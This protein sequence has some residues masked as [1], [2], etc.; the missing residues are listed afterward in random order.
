MNRSI[1][2]VPVQKIEGDSSA[3]VQ[4]LLAIEEPLEI[5]LGDK[6]VSITMRTPGHDYELA[7]GFLFT[8]G[9]L[10]GS[11]QIH[12]IR[13]TQTSGNPR[14]AGNSVTVDLNPGVQVD[15]ERLER[16]FYT[17]SSCG[18][19]GKASI[20]AL[21]VQGCPVLPK[22]SLIVTSEVVHRLPEALRHQQA[23]FERTGGLHAAALFDAKGNLVLLHE[24]I[25]RHNAVDKVIGAEMLRD[26]TPLSDKLLLVSGRASF[27][28][29]QK[30]LMA[31]IPILAAVG[32]P[33][34]LA[35]ETAQR[36]QMTLLGF[37][38]DG[39]F[40]IYSGASR[41]Q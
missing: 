27:E 41:I 18:V 30:A 36:F 5:R 28:L 6:T 8:E 35:V 14:Q 23:V 11:A 13:R 22:D 34:S 15:F 1:L 21:H 31:G 7:A 39:R 24:D 26:H 3:P 12:R 16:H 38:R 17:T 20:E 9:I 33:S 10:Q 32:A 19:C 2:T 37:V 4:D 25:G 40:N 29:V